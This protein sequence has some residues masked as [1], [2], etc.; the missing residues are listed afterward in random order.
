M[1]CGLTFC[2]IFASYLFLIQN[3]S[4]VAHSLLDSVSTAL[5]SRSNP[6]H[7]RSLVC[8]ALFY[9][10]FCRVHVVIVLRRF[11]AADSSN[12]FTKLEAYLGL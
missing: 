1:P 4:D 6:L 10:Q 8:I 7:D 11:A 3:Y 12:F 9:V 5:S 2:P